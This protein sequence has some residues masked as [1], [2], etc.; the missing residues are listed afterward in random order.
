[1]AGDE[2]EDED[3]MVAH[4]R[5]ISKLCFLNLWYRYLHAATPDLELTVDLENSFIQ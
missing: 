5:V 4:G 3:F 2:G 1:M